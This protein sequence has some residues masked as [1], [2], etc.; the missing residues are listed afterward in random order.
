MKIGVLSDTHLK[1]PHSEFKKVIEFHF[2]DVEKILH[3]GDFVDWS[4]AE[5]LSSLKELI[6]VCGNMDPPDIR[7]AFPHKRII[8]IGGFRIGLI[9]GGGSPFGIESRV[10]EE[11]DEV[12]AIV[13]GHTH[14]PANHQVK[15]ILFFN[16]GS[17]TRSFIHRATLGILHIG[18]KIE[19]EIIKI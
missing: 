7:K 6:A 5:Y 13:Y 17:P 11:F 14:T 10:K 12:A 4:V 19:G 15:N 9:H 8:E 16:A 2:R 18:E 3:A 1:E